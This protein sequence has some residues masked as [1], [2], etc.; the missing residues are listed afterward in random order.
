MDLDGEP[1]RL[2]IFDPRR[3][4][5]PISS[6]RVLAP[7]YTSCPIQLGRPGRFQDTPLTDGRFP[8]QRKV[9]LSHHT[10]GRSRGDES[11]HL[12]GSYRAGLDVG[13]LLWLGSMARFRR[14]PRRNH[15]HHFTPPKVKVS[16]WGNSPT[17]LPE[18]SP[19]GLPRS[20]G[21]V[22]IPPRMISI[23]DFD[24]Q[25]SFWGSRWTHLIKNRFCPSRSCLRL[26]STSLSWSS[27]ITR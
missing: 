24:P 14:R 27:A 16:L 23:H 5:I 26:R 2:R 20:Q 9:F 19:C 1:N 3:A 8:T 4:A 10:L 18:G 11:I 17:I 12:C 22:I 7:P 21:C 6:Q 25:A 13:R 15:W